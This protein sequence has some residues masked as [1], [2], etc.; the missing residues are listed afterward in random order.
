MQR[1]KSYARHA[2]RC[3]AR[4]EQQVQAAL[5]AARRERSQ[6]KGARTALRGLTN[7]IFKS[8]DATRNKGHRY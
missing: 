7:L 4:C 6:R 8:Q 2:K 5:A 3:A 1:W